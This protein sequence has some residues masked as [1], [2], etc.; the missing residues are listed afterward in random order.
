LPYIVKLGERAVGIGEIVADTHGVAARFGKTPT[1]Q[2]LGREAVSRMVRKAKADRVGA[3]IADLTV[4]GAVPPYNE[5]LAG[6]LVAMLM[7]SPQ[8]VAEYRRRYGGTPSVIAPHPALSPRP[9]SSAK[10]QQ[11]GW[12]VGRG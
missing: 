3:A 6:K 4:C 7:A 10:E 1:K 2:G 9:N 11:R 5:I 8:M 12:G